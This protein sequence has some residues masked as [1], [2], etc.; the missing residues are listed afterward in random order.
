MGVLLIVL[1]ASLLLVS[2]IGVIVS[3]E[4][5][6]SLAP[7]DM[8]AIETVIFPSAAIA[9]AAMVSFY[10]TDLYDLRIV[11]RFRDFALRLLQAVGL[12][13]VLLGFVYVV[14]PEAVI[15]RRTLLITVA[16][17]VA[18]TVALRA[19]W[20]ALLRR[21]PFS[22]RVL[23]LGTGRLA[24]SLVRLIDG[25]PELRLS[26]IGCLDEHAGSASDLPVAGPMERLRE[27]VQELRPDRIV[28]A[29]AE[30]RGRLPTSALLHSRFDG[31]LVEDGVDVYERLAGKLAIESMTPSSLIFSSDFRKSRFARGTQR[32]LSMTVAAV[33]V[34]LTA[35]FMALIAVIIRMESAGPALFIQSRIGLHGRPFRLMKFR[36]MRVA[37]GEARSFWVKD[38]EDRLTR[39]GRF[40]RRS[41]LDE[42]PQFINVLR[43]DMNL[44][45]PRPQP[46]EN[47]EL[48]RSAIPYYEFRCVVRPGVTGW[49]Q[50]RYGYANNLFEET[51]KMRYD[52]YYIKRMSVLF[53]VLILLE[54]VKIMLFGRGAHATTVY[55]EPI[56]EEA[57]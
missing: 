25:A 35:P 4:E 48:F 55:D 57:K 5:R 1:E 21:R 8:L 51:E 11:R 10:Y 13:I 53:D 33:A 29:L 12:T 36:T 34:V 54:T 42:L 17:T 24:A 32:L 40:L 56:Q 26:I 6:M 52:L 38:N 49:A 20:Y 18:V 27:I 28:V 16:A 50:I 3:L 14:F 23:I 22:D 44:V 37:D 15:S 41:R 43:G 19:G 2:A 30:R 47:A 31:I 46:I 39:L 9:A 7:L 45:G